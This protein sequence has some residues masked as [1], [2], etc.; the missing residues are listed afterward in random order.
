[1]GP[2]PCYSHRPG[3]SFKPRIA[4]TNHGCRRCRC[5]LTAVHRPWVPT[6]LWSSAPMCATLML[7]YNTYELN[8]EGFP[9]TFSSSCFPA[10]PLSTKHRRA[11]RPLWLSPE[12]AFAAMTSAQAHYRS[13]TFEAPPSATPQDYRRWCPSARTCCHGQPIPGEL[14]HPPLLSSI[15]C[16]YNTLPLT[17]LPWVGALEGARSHHRASALPA[18]TPFTSESLTPHAVFHPPLLADASHLP[19]RFSTGPEPREAIICQNRPCP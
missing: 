4:Y 19:D 9:C 18:L 5:F 7:A 13:L 16:G 10:A 15:H 2:A 1:L 11:D 14:L 17:L 3:V 12:T 6:M 8:V